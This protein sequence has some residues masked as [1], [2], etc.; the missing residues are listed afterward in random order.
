YKTRLDLLPLGAG[1]TSE[2]PPPPRQVSTPPPGRSPVPRR[3]YRS[4]QPPGTP[5]PLPPGAATPPP[6]PGTPGARDGATVGTI[7]LQ[8]Q[9]AGADVLIDGE[10]W[11]SS[12]NERLMVQLS[13]G[14]HHVEIRKTGYGSL[15]TDIDVRGGVT[16]P[17]NFSLSPQ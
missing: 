15:S 14:R 10:R 4:P 1:E 5:M 16:T 6:P 11:T 12:D 13:A 2:T 7:V 8:V 9:P 3:P 17:L